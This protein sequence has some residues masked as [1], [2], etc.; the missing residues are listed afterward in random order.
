MGASGT[1][2]ERLIWLVPV[3]VAV[4][5]LW[6][7]RAGLVALAAALPLFGSP[8]GGPYLGALD[9]AGL[10]AIATAWRR[11]EPLSPSP[12]AWPVVAFVV[13]SL[14]TLVPPIFLPPSW[15]PAV[16]LG[17]VQALPGVESWS[18]L[19]T[20]RA[21]L[22]LLLGVGLFVAV[23]RAFEGRSVRPLALAVAAGL[24]CA[25]VVGLLSW[26]G[27]LDLDGYRVQ[28]GTRLQSLFFLSGWYS[29]YIVV[30][31]PVAL[32]ALAVGGPWGRRLLV[33]LAALSMAS[34]ALTHQR[35]AWVA[36]AGQAVFYGAVIGTHWLGKPRRLRRQALVAAATL[37]LAAGLVVASGGSPARLLERARSA[38][39]GVFTRMPMWTAAGE[40]IR[41][42]PAMGWGLGSF[43]LAFDL[44]RPPG[45]PGS[46]PFRGTAHN[47]YLQVGAECGLIGLAALALVGWAAAVGLRR[48]RRGDETLALGLG[49][50]LVGVAVYGLVQ[51]MFY[52]RNIHWLIWLVLGAVAVVSR[53][54]GPALPG[55]AAQAATLVALALLPLRAIFAE[56]PASD[57]RRS[58][59]LHERE[60]HPDGDFRWTEA[61][62]SQRIPWAGETLVLSLA[63][64]H[65][66]AAARPP[67]TVM[68]AVDGEELVRLEI[69]GGWEEHRFFLGPP[70]AEWLVLTLEVE[71]TFRPFSDYRAYPD[72]E[73]PNDIRSL[74]IAVRDVR[75]ATA[76]A[77]PRR[78]SGSGQAQG[79]RRPSR[80]EAPAS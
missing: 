42:R 2:A 34:L 28:H 17:T 37:A 52:L 63:N 23:R 3:A 41:E 75:W 6:R 50:S 49:A 72:F 70:R 76:A 10:A 14:G 7:R 56:P 47:L 64:G 5:G 45:T 58:F 32:A 39:T 8:P 80:A 71:P 31:A 46:H 53:P 35:G 44:K 1:V 60:P 29:E 78:R 19:Y 61:R 62:S 79:G 21:A 65:P 15:Q 9:F 22:D 69:K 36:V 12:L 27:L 26:V 55:R 40:M 30:A 33:P 24:A 73:G 67:V 54:S 74:G 4:C 59:G 68:V 38:Q 18:A 48:P 11:R 66:R 57:T 25:L 20:W 16:L 13:V 51:H 77:S 43:S